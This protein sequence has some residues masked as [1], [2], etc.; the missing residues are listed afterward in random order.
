VKL[1]CFRFFASVWVG[2]AI[3]NKL[4]LGIRRK[5][6]VGVEICGVEGGE[7]CTVE[8]LGDGDEIEGE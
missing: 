4:W 1:N 2:N 5:M 8:L 6:Q 7:E 3:K